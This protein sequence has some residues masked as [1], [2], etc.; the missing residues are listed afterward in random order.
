[1]RSV[2][3]LFH[4]YKMLKPGHLQLGKK[5]KRSTEVNDDVPP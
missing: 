4:V 1:M 2:L 5:K 3:D